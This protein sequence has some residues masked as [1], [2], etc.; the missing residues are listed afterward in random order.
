MRARRRSAAPPKNLK[1]CCGRADTLQY[2]HI[3]SGFMRRHRTGF[4]PPS[5]S[6]GRGGAFETS[7]VDLPLEDLRQAGGGPRFRARPRSCRIPRRRSPCCRPTTSGAA[8]PAAFRG[9]AR[10]CRA[11]MAQIG[12][13]RWAVGCAG[14][15]PLCQQA[16]RPGGWAQHLQPGVLRGVLGG[17]GHPDRGRAHRGGATGRFPVGA[18]AVNGVINIVTRKATA[19][20]DGWSR[21]ARTARVAW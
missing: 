1:I 8:A 19:T 18:N 11:S 16:T 2:R 21:S 4:F 3:G 13:A 9:P 7:L 14:A 12:S 5:C 20:R 10:R 17:P 15:G 6:G